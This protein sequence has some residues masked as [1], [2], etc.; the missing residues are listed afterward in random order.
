M[1]KIVIAVL[2][3]ALTITA[4]PAFAAPSDE[5]YTWDEGSNYDDDH[6]ELDD[7]GS[8]DPSED[9]DPSDYNYGYEYEE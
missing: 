5:E 1:K 6:S 9:D 8:D 3:A 2:T 7:Y 4:V